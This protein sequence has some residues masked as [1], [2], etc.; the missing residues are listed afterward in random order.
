M[1]TIIEAVI[2]RICDGKWTIQGY[3]EEE[4]TGSRRKQESVVMP[5]SLGQHNVMIE[6]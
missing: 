1:I 4:G 6:L 5:P 2:F 3:L